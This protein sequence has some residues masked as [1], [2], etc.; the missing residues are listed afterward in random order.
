L[1]ALEKDG[2]ID[3]LW[4]KWFGPKTKFNIPRDKKLTPISAFRQ[5]G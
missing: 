3:A 2:Q 5:A 4:I 1:V